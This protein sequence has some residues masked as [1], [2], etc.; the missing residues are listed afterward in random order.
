VFQVSDFFGGKEISR[1]VFLVALIE[2]DADVGIDDLVALNE[3]GVVLRMSL[4][5]ELEAGEPSDE[6]PVALRKSPATTPRTGYRR[7]TRTG[8]LAAGI[9]S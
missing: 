1:R 5:N 8:D 3:D 9:R 7:L 6:R 2:Q 4:G